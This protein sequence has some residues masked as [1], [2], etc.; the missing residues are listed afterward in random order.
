MGRSGVWPKFEANKTDSKSRGGRTGLDAVWVPLTL[1]KL[2]ILLLSG[3]T[4]DGLDA[5]WAQVKIGEPTLLV[6]SKPF[7]NDM[8]S[9]VKRIQC[10]LWTAPFLRV[11]F[12]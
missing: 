8:M 2:H 10:F 3:G 9:V 5:V 4:R 11:L 12:A 1:F 6:Y 7:P